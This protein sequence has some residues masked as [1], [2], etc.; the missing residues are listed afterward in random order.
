[1]G[2]RGR[3]SAQQTDFP[4]PFSFFLVPF[5]LIPIPL[6]SVLPCFA[7]SFLL[8]ARFLALRLFVGGYCL[9]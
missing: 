9:V 7:L 6:F 4:C 8:F 3:Q 1:M 2:G 5:F